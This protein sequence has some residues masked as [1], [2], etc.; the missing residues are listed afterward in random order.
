P[1]PG[2][3]HV[4]PQ[5]RLGARGRVGGRDIE[6]A[7]EVVRRPTRA[8]G[9]GTDNC[10]ALHWFL[11]INDIGHFAVSCSGATGIAPALANW[12]TSSLLNPSCARISALCSPCSGARREGTRSIP[13]RVSGL[14]TV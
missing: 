10:D 7:G 9:A 8:D 11:R 13:R 14:L 12:L 4:G 1:L 5:R 6:A 3:V 2:A